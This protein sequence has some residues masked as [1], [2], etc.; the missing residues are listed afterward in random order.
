MTLY[1]KNSTK[2]YWWFNE[3]KWTV[4]CK[5]L[6][7]IKYTAKTRQKKKLKFPETWMTELTFF[8]V[9]T[10]TSEL[11]LIAIFS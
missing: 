7:N 6:Y 4:S 8:N 2:M 1:T 11:R 9:Y 3:I 10:L 5:Q